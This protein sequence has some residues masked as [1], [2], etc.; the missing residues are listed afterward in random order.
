MCITG[1]EV[2][3]KAIYEETVHYLTTGWSSNC[4]SWV[5]QVQVLK[6]W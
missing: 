4:R 3:K 6:K 2:P 5:S 1:H